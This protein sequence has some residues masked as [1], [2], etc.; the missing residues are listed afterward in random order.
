[1]ENANLKLCGKSIDCT[2]IGVDTSTTST[3]R[4]TKSQENSMNSVCDKDGQMLGSL[5][6]GRNQATNDFAA[7]SAFR[8]KTTLTAPHVSV[9][10]LKM[11]CKKA[12]SLSVRHVDAEAVQ[13]ETDIIVNRITS[14]L[15]YASLGTLC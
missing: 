15:L 8:T 7:Y 5:P 10:S 3:T 12:S 13:V 11:I 9:E 1:M 4:N 14:L 6:S 2:I